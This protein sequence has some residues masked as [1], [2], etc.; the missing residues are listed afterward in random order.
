MLDECGVCDGDGSSCRLH[1]VVTT[2]VLCFLH[3]FS[4]L[5]TILALLPSSHLNKNNV[6]AVALAAVL[7]LACVLTLVLTIRLT[8]TKLMTPSHFV[9][10]LSVISPILFFSLC[11]LSSPLLSFDVLCVDVWLLPSY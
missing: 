2:Q 10:L 1:V 9:P 8:L 7:T 5:P 3:L 6:V 11:F 4:V